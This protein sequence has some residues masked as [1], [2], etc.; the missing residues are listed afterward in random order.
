MGNAQHRRVS[1]LSWPQLRT[2]SSQ[3]ILPGPP[4]IL[5]R[6]PMTDLDVGP[7]PN[8]KTGTSRWTYLVLSKVGTAMVQIVIN[9]Q[10][11]ASALNP[12]K[13]KR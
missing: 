4:T 7:L 11:K 2:L 6:H 3:E 8:E 13:D 1:P 10:A 12:V 9:S 5:E